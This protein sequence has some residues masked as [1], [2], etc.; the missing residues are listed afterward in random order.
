MYSGELYSLQF[1]QLIAQKS[2]SLGDLLRSFTWLQDDLTDNETVA[3]RSLNRIAERDLQFTLDMASAPWVK[4]GLVAYEEGAFGSLGALFLTD[5]D[6]AR[7]LLANTVHAPVWSSDI[8]IITALQD[9][10]SHTDSREIEPT[11]TTGL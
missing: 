4:D 8:R 5:P 3:L 1:L 6:L 11:A 2:Q 9:L 7:Q 10:A